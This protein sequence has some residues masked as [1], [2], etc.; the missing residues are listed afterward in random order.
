MKSTRRSV[1]TQ[2]DTIRE[3]AAVLARRLT[4]ETMADVM[5]SLL[6]C[7]SDDDL[8]DHDADL[9]ERLFDLLT[10]MRPDAVSVAVQG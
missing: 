9:G 1:R 3:I 7:S 4:V 6:N 10:E 8:S 5:N 2:H